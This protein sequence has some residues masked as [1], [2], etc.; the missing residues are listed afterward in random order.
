VTDEKCHTTRLVDMKLRRLTWILLKLGNESNNS[1]QRSLQEPSYLTLIRAR[2]RLR[3]FGSTWNFADIPSLFHLFM[4]KTPC[5][6]TIFW[7]IV[8]PVTYLWFGIPT[9][10]CTAHVTAPLVVSACIFVASW[11]LSCHQT[12]SVMLLWHC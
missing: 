8:L 1:M 5:P 6:C 9:A 12:C 7:G 4:S 10:Y 2:D 3:L 11:V